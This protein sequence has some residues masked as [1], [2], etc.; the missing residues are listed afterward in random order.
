M[1]RCELQIVGPSFSLTPPTIQVDKAAIMFDPHTR[2]SRGFGFVTMETVE[3][4]DAAIAALNATDLLGKTMT[5]EKVTQRS[6][7]NV[8]LANWPVI[9]GP[10]WSCSHSYSWT[11]LWTSQKGRMSVVPFFLPF[12]FSGALIPRK[13]PI[14]LTWACR[15]SR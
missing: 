1:A 14:S 5:V 15:S 6:A 4:A 11:V 7:F 12:I 3:G 9:L 2:E 8:I 13:S 10:S